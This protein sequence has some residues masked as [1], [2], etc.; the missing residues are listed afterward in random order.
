MWQ[1]VRV[2]I[3]NVVSIYKRVLV[4]VSSLSTLSADP[5]GDALFSTFGIGTLVRMKCLITSLNALHRDVCTHMSVALF[6]ALA[7]HKWQK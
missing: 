2:S 6:E 4:G 5:A 3:C 1:D 7:A